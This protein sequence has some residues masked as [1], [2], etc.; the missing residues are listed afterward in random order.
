MTFAQNIHIRSVYL[1]RVDT[2]L[3]VLPNS[4]ASATNKKYPVVFMLHGFSGNYKQWQKII[5]LQNYANQYQFIL[6]CPDGLY[7]S[8]YINS[9][10]IAKQQYASFFFEDLYPYILKNYRADSQHIFIT[11][12][13][14]GGYG[15]YSL[16]LEKPTLFKSVAATS[17]LFDLRLF[18]KKFGLTKILGNLTEN[19]KHSWEKFA[20]SKQIILAQ[21]NKMLANKLLFFDCGTEDVF[22]QSN[23]DLETVCK[24]L[25]IS[26]T[27]IRNNG[28][29]D[30]AYW[31]KNILLHF[32]FFSKQVQ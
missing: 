17:A 19:T 14:M 12:L 2:S 24:K 25:Q 13:S 20:I 28:Q 5:D 1:P 3:V 4:Y 16:F 8:W 31:K 11:G 7:D 32:D 30:V 26:A 27:F 9:P 29:H 10:I 6:V 18:A 23:I 21:E 15:A 22:L